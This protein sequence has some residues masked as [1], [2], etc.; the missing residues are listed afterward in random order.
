[1][2]IKTME[3]IREDRG[4]DK[5][6]SETIFASADSK[7]KKLAYDEAIAAGYITLY[8]MWNKCCSCSGDTSGGGDESI[9]MKRDVEIDINVKYSRDIEIRHVFQCVYYFIKHKT[10]GVENLKQLFISQFTTTAKGEDTEV[11]RLFQIIIYTDDFELYQFY[12]TMFDQTQFELMIHTHYDISEGVLVKNKESRIKHGGSRIYLWL[13]PQYVKFYRNF[14]EKMRNSIISL[15][16]V[17]GSQYMNE[18][19]AH[20]M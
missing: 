15:Y 8:D 19:G 5:F 17:A 11:N 12:L 16:L 10:L 13:A 9:V 2:K 1:M 14:T 7:L 3:D 20:I 6:F 4:V 18:C